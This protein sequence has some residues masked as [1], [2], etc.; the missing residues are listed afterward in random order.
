M[1]AWCLG[2]ESIGVPRLMVG[3]WI[4]TQELTSLY[5]IVL[6]RHC[7]AYPNLM[8]PNAELFSLQSH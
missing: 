8:N 4:Q 1:S 3:Y 5:G 2:G 7:M 6:R